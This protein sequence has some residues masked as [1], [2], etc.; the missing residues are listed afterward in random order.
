MHINFATGVALLISGVN[1]CG[2]VYAFFLREQEEPD[3]QFTRTK[4][5]WAA[6]LSIILTFLN[7]TL[8]LVL[9]AA[10]SFRWVRFYPGAPIYHAIPAGLALSLFG[11]VAALFGTGGKRWISLVASVTL[12]FLWILAAVA[13]VAV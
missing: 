10:W 6:P 3:Y 4:L 7:Q 11:L 8:Y 13:S 12:G 5:A 9:L 1:L 2:L